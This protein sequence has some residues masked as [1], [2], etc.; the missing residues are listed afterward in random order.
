MSKTKLGDVLSS[1][2]RYLKVLLHTD[3]SPIPLEDNNDSITLNKKRKQQV[4]D[5]HV[6]F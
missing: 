4:I 6:N 3:H 1:V 5:F 2:L